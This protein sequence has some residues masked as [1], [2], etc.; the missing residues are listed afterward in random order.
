MET[1]KLT[2]K[3]EIFENIK[4][5]GFNLITFE[6]TP[7]YFSKFTSNKRNTVEDVTNDPS[8]VKS[9]DNVEFLCCGETLTCSNPQIKIENNLFCVS[10]DT[11]DEVVENTIEPND[12][13]E[14]TPVVETVD[15]QEQ[16]TTTEVV[17][18]VVEPKEEVEDTTSI[19]DV[20]SE[21]ENENKEESISV[22]GVIENFLNKSTVIV[23]GGGI[24]RV[25]SNG[26]VMGSDKSLPSRN[27]HLQDLILKSTV[28]EFD[29]PFDLSDKLNEL[30]NKGYLFVSQLDI[31]SLDKGIL[32]LKSRV[33]T[34]LD[35]LRW[36]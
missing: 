19:E 4:Y 31:T 28:I 23:V 17:E 10:F 21:P 35:M 12:V 5:R 15:K 18:P 29:S 32:K 3:K 30:S 2:L 11:P 36:L 9:F 8:L 13:V 34:R 33:V 7:F 20:K 24:A 22:Y 27:E 14:E 16:E 1:L 25:M 26:R 6:T